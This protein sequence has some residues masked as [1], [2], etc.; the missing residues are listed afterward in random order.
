MTNQRR[1]QRRERH[2]PRFDAVQQA[3]AGAAQALS[4]VQRLPPPIL[5]SPVTDVQPQ[6]TPSYFGAADAASVSASTTPPPATMSFSSIPNPYDPQP[7]TQPQAYGRDYA[8]Q[9]QMLQQQRQQQVGLPPTDHLRYSGY[10]AHSQ[11]Q[12]EL[13]AQPHPELHAQPQR[14]Q[15]LLFQQ[16]LSQQRPVQYDGIAPAAQGT[17]S[18]PPMYTTHASEPHQLAAQVSSVPTATTSVPGSASALSPSWQHPAHG[19]QLDT[20][21]QATSVYYTPTHRQAVVADPVHTVATAAPPSTDVPM[22]TRADTV[23]PPSFP[24]AS[25][26]AA[27]ALPQFAQSDAAVTSSS[28]TSAP[29]PAPLFSSSDEIESRRNE[30]VGVASTATGNVDLQTIANDCYD[31]DVRFL[32]HCKKVTYPLWPNARNWSSINDILQWVNSMHPDEHCCLQKP[33]K[34]DNVTCF[35]TDGTK[36]GSHGRGK[37]QVMLYFKNELGQD[38]PVTH[39]LGLLWKKFATCSH[40]ITSRG[41]CKQQATREI[42]IRPSHLHPPEF[43]E[44]LREVLLEV[45]GVVVASDAT[46]A[47]CMA[48]LKEWWRINKVAPSKRQV[49]QGKRQSTSKVSSK[50]A[51]GAS[52]PTDAS[53]TTAVSGLVPTAQTLSEAA[54]AQESFPAFG[55]QLMHFR[56]H[57][58]FDLEAML[59]DMPLHGVKL[60]DETQVALMAPPSMSEEFDVLPM[61]IQKM[62]SSEYSSFLSCHVAE[63]HYQQ[64]ALSGSPTAFPEH[65]HPVGMAPSQSLLP[66]VSATP[67]HMLSSPSSDITATTDGMSPAASTAHASSPE[68]SD[69]THHGYSHDLSGGISMSESLFRPED[70]GISITPCRHSREGQCPECLSASLG[71]TFDGADM[72][73]M[74]RKLKAAGR[75]Q[76][77]DVVALIPRENSLYIT[78]YDDKSAADAVLCGVITRSAYAVAN[79][80]AAMSSPPAYSAKVYALEEGVADSE[81]ESES[82]SGSDFSASDDEFDD[83]NVGSTRAPRH[84]TVKPTAAVRS[85]PDG[86]DVVCMYGI[87]RLR[88]KGAVKPGALLYSPPVSYLDDPMS[89]I[90]PTW[91]S[92][93]EPSQDEQAVGELTDQL[94]TTHLAA[95]SSTSHADSSFASFQRASQS[96]SSLPAGSGSRDTPASEKAAAFAR[97]RAHSTG[98]MSATSEKS[99]SDSV[100]EADEPLV[101]KQQS[102]SVW[103]AG[104]AQVLESWHFPQPTQVLLGES[105][106]AG[107]PD[108]QGISYVKTLISMNN[109]TTEKGVRRALQR[110]QQSAKGMFSALVDR[111]G[112]NTREVQDLKLRMN[113]LEKTVAEA[114]HNTEVAQLRRQIEQLNISLQTQE[115]AVQATTATL[116]LFAKPDTMCSPLCNRIRPTDIRNSRI[117][118]ALIALKSVTGS[119]FEGTQDRFLTLHQGNQLLCNGNHCTPRSNWLLLVWELPTIDL[120]G[121]APKTMRVSLCRNNKF[122]F[123]DPTT[124]LASVR[125]VSDLSKAPKLVLQQVPGTSHFC[126]LTDGPTPTQRVIA[127]HQGKPSP[128]STVSNVSDRCLFDVFWVT[129]NDKKCSDDAKIRFSQFILDSFESLVARGVEEHEQREAI[130][131]VEHAISAEAEGVLPTYESSTS[132]GN[133]GS[134]M[135]AVSTK[136]EK[137]MLSDA[138]SAT[139]S[140]RMGAASGYAVSAYPSTK[141]GGDTSHGKLPDSINPQS[142]LMQE[143]AR[144]GVKAYIISTLSGFCCVPKGTAVYAVQEMHPTSAFTIYP[145]A[146][147]AAVYIKYGDLLLVLDAQGAPL[148]VPDTTKARLSGLFSLVPNGDGSVKLHL[149]SRGM[150]LTCTRSGKFVHMTKSATQKSNS[151]Y[152]L[153][154]CSDQDGRHVVL[155]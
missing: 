151:F 70:F 145:V 8:V 142:D 134:E 28:S 87:V 58:E 41:H 46:W 23:P 95:G 42:C 150:P 2:Q 40:G 6:R 16:G 130:R 88:V 148:L 102:S 25:A 124:N 135:D 152:L 69:P 79:R 133:K 65:M 52:S 50:K 96:V 110:F 144:V 35:T 48:A 81:N 36:S 45:Y 20:Q 128:C 140:D 24:P 10:Q 123:V 93:L 132:P 117:Q 29:Q 101:N 33:P 51:K 143:I 59:E 105:L 122:L 80:A 82:E 76:E 91:G 104:V 56:T 60:A 97:S 22:V 34:G 119:D 19:F 67:H 39:Q 53:A 17:T 15:S 147:Q 5:A 153:S 92:L 137:G 57:S 89:G 141:S 129:P 86:V 66:N 44:D 118:C 116:Q 154:G 136:A 71:T 125:E 120:F 78:V 146:S 9:Q 100:F 54:T 26:T 113:D 63:G 55:S 37:V 108:S 61:D 109:N 1:Q 27:T 3:I 64:H 114:Q 62:L 84:P 74:F 155:D 49:K 94:T 68:S 106:E 14:G 12:P 77:G 47:Q 99:M 72:A 21:F 131:V 90:A 31:I 138:L 73:Y 18:Q 103:P 115:T 83:N 85:I 32:K 127:F 43:L 38:F 30:A 112:R 7:H 107:V 149:I 13:H 75:Y 121:T 139:T 98:A 4:G 126:V 11:P 111:V